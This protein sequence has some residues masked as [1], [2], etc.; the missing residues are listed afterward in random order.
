MHRAKITSDAPSRLLALETHGHRVL[1][2][3]LSFDPSQTASLRERHAQASS[4]LAEAEHRHWN[5]TGRSH[6]DRMALREDIERVREFLADEQELAPQ[7]ARGLAIFSSAPAGIF[8]VLTLPGSV[9]P[10]V[11][12]DE[13]PFVEPL[14][15]LVAGERWCVLL[16]SHRASRIFVGDREHLAE[17]AGVLDDVHRRHAQGGWSQSRY[18]R[19]IEKETGEHIRGTC[20]ILFERLRH[21]PF[22]RLLIAGP[23]E[24]HHRVE[25]ELHPDLRTRLA[26]HFESDVERATPGEGHRRA[27]PLIEADEQRR[28]QQA[29]QRL[30]DGLALPD[31]AA[32]GLEEVLELLNERRVQTL[33]LAHGFAVAGFACPVC[34]RLAAGG[35][36]CPVDGAK[37]EPRED[38]VES[39]IVLALD[40]A[41]EVVIARHRGDELAEH[42]PIA[43]LLRY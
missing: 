41:A 42:G 37:P 20:A 24:L 38:I 31:R 28:E 29:L 26:G 25:H 13:Q 8:E 14:I 7:S 1:S 27:V 34:G 3:Y 40:Q 4:L 2:L 17:A 22:D 33:F 35:E 5:D 12:I 9:D 15:E 11:M 30:S 36:P 19:G 21:R 39:A 23:A 32:V 18:Q 6:E 43:A 10:Q 16:I